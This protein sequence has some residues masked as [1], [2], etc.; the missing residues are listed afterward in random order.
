MTLFDEVNTERAR[1]NEKHPIAP[2][3]ILHPVEDPTAE[4]IAT[5]LA[6]RRE[7][8]DKAEAKGEHSWYGIIREEL[9]E[10]FTAKTPEER[11]SEIVQAMALLKRLDEET[12]SEVIIDDI[13]KYQKACSEL[14]GAICKSTGIDR[15]ARW[16]V[17]K[18]SKA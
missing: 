15:L 18:V 3:Y 10:V 2:K 12:Y 14:F 4:Q 16:I 6:W 7:D 13:E 5:S 9:S 1:Q 17:G 11:H 8:N